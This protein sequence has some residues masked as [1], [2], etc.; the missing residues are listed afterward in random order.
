MRWIVVNVVLVGFLGV[1]LWLLPSPPQP[2]DVA[3][4]LDDDADVP[5]VSEPTRPG[6]SPILVSTIAE[7]PLFSETRRPPEDLPDEEEEDDDDDEEEESE[8]DPPDPLEAKLEAVMGGSDNRWVIVRTDDDDVVRLRPGNDIE[9]W[10]LESV[11]PGRA[12]FAQDG[13]TQELKLRDY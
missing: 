11:E 4:A 13:H 10:V 1:Q 6:A 5:E 12:M 9:G 2:P 3:R 8:P 7:R